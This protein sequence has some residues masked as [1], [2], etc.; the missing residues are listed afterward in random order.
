[1][2]QIA[3]LVKVGDM[4]TSDDVGASVDFTQEILVIVAGQPV[5]VPDGEEHPLR[6]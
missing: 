1:M 4:V 3:V 2:R 5:T 6:T